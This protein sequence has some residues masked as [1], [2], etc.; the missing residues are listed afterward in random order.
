MTSSVLT[1]RTRGS[2]DEEKESAHSTHDGLFAD[3]RRGTHRRAGLLARRALRTREALEWEGR[4]SRL[5]L[6]KGDRRRADPPDNADSF[7]V[8]RGCAAG[9][10]P[11][12]IYPPTGLGKLSGYSRTRVTSSARE[13]SEGLVNPNEIRRVIAGAN[14]RHPTREVAEI[15]R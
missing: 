2:G 12:P 15:G 14:R 8:S 5:G 10:I 6:K 11:V 1:P 13:A 4:Y 7:R 9:V 3:S